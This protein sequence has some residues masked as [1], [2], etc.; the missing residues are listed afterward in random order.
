[1][2]FS[3]KSH[4]MKKVF[5][6]A[7]L[8]AFFA[9]AAN[10][11]AP[12]DIKDKDV[13]QAIKTAFDNQFDNTTM[14]NWKMKD[15]N[16][17]ASFLMNLKK[18]FA[19]FNNAGELVSKGE[20]IDKDELPTS[21]ADAVKTGYAGKEIDEVFKV[22]KGGQTQYMVKLDGEPKKKIVYDAQGNLVKEKKMEK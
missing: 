18:H 21:V 20:K 8:G 9:F 6:I 15:G 17:K 3:Q 5:L 22:E 11:Q 1:V 13:P 16:Y 7:V 14:V 19:E 2:A 10:A 4:V 12:T